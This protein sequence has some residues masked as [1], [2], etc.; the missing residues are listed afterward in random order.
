MIIHSYFTDGLYR[1]AVLFLKSFKQF[2]GESIPIVFSTR[3]LDSE[4]LSY[5]NTLYGNLE[6]RNEE[7]DFE[8]LSKKVNTPIEELKKMKKTTE[9]GF[10]HVLWKQFISVEDRYRRSIIDVMDDYIVTGHSHM[11]HIDIDMYFKGCIDELLKIIESNDISIYFRCKNSK[12]YK[13]E[14]RRV[15]GCIIGFRLNSQIRTFMEVWFKHIDSIPLIEKPRAFGQTSFYRAF[16]E[17]E[18]QFKWGHIPIKFADPGQAEDAVIWAGNR[19]NKDANLEL[20]EQD[21]LRN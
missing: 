3:N 1:W 15:L 11:L 6:I 19:G 9:H 13:N 7:I 12:K 8:R 18:H 16:L 21:F 17:T 14:W 20:F 2:H 4:R 10:F 5:L